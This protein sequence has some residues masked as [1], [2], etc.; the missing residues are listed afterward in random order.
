[1]NYGLTQMAQGK[2]VEA[3]GLFERAQ[4][5]TPSYPHLEVNLG[6]VSDRL[7]ESRVAKQ[8][9]QRALSL[10][11]EFAEGHYYYANGSCS[12]ATLATRSHTC[13]AQSR[14]ARSLAHARTL[15]MDLYS[16][17]GA[18]AAL[19]A[20][21]REPLAVVPTDPQALSYANDKTLPVTD[22]AVAREHYEQGVVLTN[23]A[24]HLE[25]ALAYRRALRFEPT[26]ADAANNLGWSLAQLGFLYCEAVAAF[27]NAVR[28]RP[29]FALAENNLH[30]VQTQLESAR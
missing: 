8:R 25:A 1:M 2:Y 4:R 17:Q 19:L 23:A 5:S 24:R 20:L 15:L 16:A 21:A 7:G 18:E 3:K 14:A 29:G 27:E 11:P 10:Q 22:A 12:T 28:L 26:S 9:F 6:I 13:N 30:W